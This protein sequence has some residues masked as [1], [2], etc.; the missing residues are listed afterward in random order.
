M[1]W[2]VVPLIG[3]SHLQFII[4]TVG[5]NSQT[6]R[7]RLRGQGNADRKPLTGYRMVTIPESWPKFRAMAD[8]RSSD[9]VLSESG[10]VIPIVLIAQRGVLS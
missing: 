9:F 1:I 2:P 10:R 7:D 6:V 5:Y 4:R 3:K 8:L